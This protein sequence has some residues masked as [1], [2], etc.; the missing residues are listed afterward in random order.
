MLVGTADKKT[1]GFITLTSTQVL[2]RIG[3]GAGATYT[4]RNFAGPGVTGFNA[5]RGAS[6]N[7]QLSDTTPAGQNAGTIGSLTSVAGSVSC[8]TK[9]PGSGT[10]TINGDSTAGA[11]SGTLSS[12]LVKCNATANFALINGLTHV[13]SSPASVEIGGGSGETYFA[14][15]ETSSGGFFFSSMAPGLYSLTNGHVHWSSAVLTQSGVPGAAG[16]TVTVSGDATC[17]TQ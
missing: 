7:A 15:F 2:V 4:E 17:G 6:F 10:I 13:G 11:I 1:G 14:S 8:G 3:A 12:I 16:H 9:T 5:A